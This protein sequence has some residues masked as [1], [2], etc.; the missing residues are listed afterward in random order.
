MLQGFVW[1]CDWLAFCKWAGSELKP[2]WPH[3]HEKKKKKIDVADRFEPLKKRRLKKTIKKKVN[4]LR[5]DFLFSRHFRTFFFLADLG[6]R[7]HSVDL[8]GV[9]PLRKLFRQKFEH[10]TENKKIPGKIK[11]AQLRSAFGQP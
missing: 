11:F 2:D 9:E 4:L 7:F 8:G 10:G 5:L 6:N 1:I 3:G